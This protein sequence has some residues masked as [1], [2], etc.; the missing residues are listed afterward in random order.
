MWAAHCVYSPWPPE[1][2][3]DATGYRIQTLRNAGVT[4]YFT[5]SNGLFIYGQQA[6]NDLET[7][8]GVCVCVFKMCS[9]TF[10]LPWNGARVQRFFSLLTR[11]AVTKTLPRTPVTFALHSHPYQSLSL[12]TPIQISHFRS[13]VPSKS[14]S[15]ALYSHPNFPRF[16][17]N[18]SVQILVP[19]DCD[20]SFAD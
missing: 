9:F 15:F 20:L 18:R 2:P 8:F 5:T 10:K 7:P 11:V 1:R 12:Y 19:G 16:V 6:W 4:V 14:V 13:I 17:R 3:G